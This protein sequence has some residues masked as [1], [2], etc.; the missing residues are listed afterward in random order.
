MAM[1]GLRPP[2]RIRRPHVTPATNGQ[3]DLATVL[4]EN[5]T[6]TPLRYRVTLA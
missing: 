2:G 4:A 1:A 3:S 6:D 5:G